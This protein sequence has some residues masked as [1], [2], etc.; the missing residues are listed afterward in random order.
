PGHTDVNAARGEGNDP[1]NQFSIQSMMD[2]PSHF[3][4]DV[5]A[6]YVDTLPFPN[7]PAYFTFDARLAWQVGKVELSVVGQ[8]LYEP[9]HAEFGTAATRQEIPRSVYGKVS[10][11]F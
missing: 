8:N 5:T 1:Q 2:L 3:Q 11:R 7:V 6:R 9:R 10:C 4:F